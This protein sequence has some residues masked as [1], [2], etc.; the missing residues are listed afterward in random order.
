MGQGWLTVLHVSFPP[1]VTPIVT[2][3]PTLP[4]VAYSHYSPLRRCVPWGLIRIFVATHLGA[5]E[6]RERIGVKRKKIDNRGGPEVC[7]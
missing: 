6:N 1:I 2:F 5:W 4:P 3:L 7:K